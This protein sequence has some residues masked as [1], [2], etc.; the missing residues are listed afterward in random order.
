MQNKS[1]EE[2]DPPKN[3]F[4]ISKYFHYYL[5]QI[6][7]RVPLTTLRVRDSD[8]ILGM[9]VGYANYKAYCT[10]INEL[11]LQILMKAT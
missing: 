10:Q 4:R 2:V 6:G 8:F 3:V 11:N 5:F 1:N 9:V 7:S